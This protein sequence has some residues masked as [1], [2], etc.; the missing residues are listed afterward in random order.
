MAT[1]SNFYMD[2]LSASPMHDNP[3]P[4]YACFWGPGWNDGRKHWVMAGIG[5]GPNRVKQDIPMDDLGAY[6][7]LSK[8]KKG[9]GWI[10]CQTSFTVRCKRFFPAQVK[11]SHPD[12]HYLYH[13]DDFIVGRVN[14]APAIM[15]PPKSVTVILKDFVLDTSIIGGTVQVWGDS[16]NS[17]VT[18]TDNN[19]GTYSG[20]TYSTDHLQIFA[21]S[22]GSGAGRCLIYMDTVPLLSSGLTMWIATPDVDPDDPELTP[23]PIEVP[24][25]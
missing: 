8:G 1:C 16:D 14:A 5:T 10:P 23:S 25:L 11:Q 13:R 22:S 15:G 19:D 4:A 18:L 6:N 9:A 3:S 12:S 21:T 20:I 24:P 17:C 7:V 2:I